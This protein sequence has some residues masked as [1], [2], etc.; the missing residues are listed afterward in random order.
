M[1]YASKKVRTG[2]DMLA[3]N[4]VEFPCAKAALHLLDAAKAVAGY[5][6]QPR[7]LAPVGSALSPRLPTTSKSFLQGHK[8]LLQSSMRARVALQGVTV[9]IM[10]ISSGITFQDQI[11]R[12]LGMEV[13][14]QPPQSEPGVKREASLRRS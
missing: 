14:Q 13:A 12:A 5:A 1:I 6:N 7:A 8:N 4:A 9:G 11:K 2:F 10:A 3:H